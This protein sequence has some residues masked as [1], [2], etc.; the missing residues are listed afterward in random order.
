[1]FKKK[2]GFFLRV[3]LFGL[4]TVLASLATAA[5]KE[6]SYLFSPSGQQQ[7]AADENLGSA[8]TKMILAFSIVAALGVAA[9]YASKKMLPK[10]ACGQGK[11]IRVLE[12]VHLGSRK[13]VH[14]LQI[15]GQ[16]ILIGSTPDRITKLADIMDVELEKNFPLGR[17]NPAGETQ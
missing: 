3:V 10:F 14:L 17:H 7:G 15:G 9:I 13:M 11:T 2:K 8:F 1:M 6:P 16:Q 4:G 12:T 5:D